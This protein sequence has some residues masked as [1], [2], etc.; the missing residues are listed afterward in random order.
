MKKLTALL[1]LLALSAQ[2]EDR[3]M[4]D[5]Y[6]KHSSVC[7]TAYQAPCERWLQPRRMSLQRD[8]EHDLTADIGIGTNSYGRPSVSLGG[9]W[10]PVGVGGLKAGLF[11]AV[12]S[13]YTCQELRTCAVVAGLV[14]SATAGKSVVQVLYVPSVGDGTVSVVSIR[15]GMAF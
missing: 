7:R 1:A 6:T 8:F 10:Q 12:V 14:A 2:A 13:G 3:V 5:M 4:A 15:V 9:L 11:G